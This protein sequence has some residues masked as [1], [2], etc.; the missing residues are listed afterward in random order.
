MQLTLKNASTA[1][2]GVSPSTRSTAAPR[3]SHVAHASKAQKG[4]WAGMDAGNDVSDDQ[5]DI[6]R[7]RGMV[8]ELFQGWGG[9][10]GTQNAIMASSDYISQA[11]RTFNNVEDGFYISPSFLDKLSIHIAKNFMNLP[12]IK[13]PLILGIWGGKGQGK[14]FQC[15]LA[16]KKLGITPIVMSAGELE[17]GN[18]GEPAKLLRQ[19]YREA[20]DMIKKGKMCCL[21]IN[22]LDA[23][24][25]RFGLSTQYTVNNQMVNATLMNIADNPTNVQLPGVYK[26]EEIPRV[27]IVCTGNDFSTLYAPLIRDGR[28]E[29]YYWNP[30]REDRV[31][32]CMGIFAEDNLNRGQVEQLVDA[33]PGQSIDFFG[34]LRAR[35]YDD[36]VREFVAQIGHENLNKRLINSKEGKVKFEKPTMSL[37]VLMHYGKSLVGEQDNVKR[38]QLADAYLAGAEL[39]GSTG[40]SVPEQ[41]KGAKNLNLSEN[42]PAQ[43][44]SWKTADS[45]KVAEAPRAAAPAP[46]RYAPAPTPAA[47]S[48]DRWARESAP[49]AAPAQRAAA[50]PAGALSASDLAKFKIAD[51]VEIGAK[52]GVSGGRNATRDSLTS[53]LLKAGVTAAD[54]T[55]GQMAELKS[56]GSSFASAPSTPSYSAPAPAAAAPAAASGDRWSS[57]SSSSR[58]SSSGGVSSGSADA[59]LSAGDLAAFKIADLVEIG[60]KKGVSGGRNA[61]RDGLV[62]ALVKAGVSLTDLS[63]GQLVDLGTKLGKAGLS[64]DINAARAEL[65]SLVGGSGSATASWRASPAP[66]STP[67]A[68]QQP[69]ASWRSTPSS[70]SSSSGGDRWASYSRGSTPAASGSGSASS[71]GG[72]LSA[73]DL[74]VLRIDD[75]RDLVSKTGAQLPREATKDGVI[76]AL[77]S[78]GVSLNDCTR[79]MLVDLATK[80]GA[81][82]AKDAEGLRRN[83]ASVVGGSSGGSA[84]SWRSSPAP[85]A[86]SAP[87]AAPA[88]GDR[89]SKYSAGSTKAASWRRSGSHNA[90]GSKLSASDLSILR[91]DDLA[92][93][94]KKTGAQV[95]RDST[96]DG[97]ISALVSKGVS[98]NEC[99][100]G[101]L[102]DLANKLGAPMARDVDGLRKNLA[103]AVGKGSYSAAPAASTSNWRSAPAESSSSSSSSGDRWASYSRSSGGSSGSSAGAS[104][105]SGAVY[106]ADLSA[107]KVDVLADMARKKGISVRNATKDSLVRELTRS[108]TLNDLSRGQLVEI[109]HNIGQSPSGSVEQMRSAVAAAASQ[110]QSARSTAGSR[111]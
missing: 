77:V 106:E 45:A 71:A 82:L 51:L 98:L 101:M 20:S 33:F 57:Y 31:G 41:Y 108:L 79:G 30:T 87:A 86:S 16:F 91:I 96:K 11:Q 107:F 110:R 9:T 100:R 70:S 47:S 50:A 21:F 28:M 90:S 34:A 5:Q 105:G 103:S 81:S 1:K 18:A 48:G 19:R 27:P 58:G 73:A 12:K 37:D 25:G 74:S 44:G 15:M 49:A 61:T 2:S 80:L 39:A 32:V 62:D 97:V 75:L 24:A 64:R 89:W 60:A 4:R 22:D 43:R 38:V 92:E 109:L 54:L 8:D 99:T 84:A 65:A 7:G 66:T 67:A 111:W 68:S 88:G 72:K 52:K 29:K 104:G 17:S 102:V 59:K 40:S 69:P 83:L 76:S 94:A 14:T 78:K 3:Q 36:K 63:R 35:V 56:G 46:E 10:A 53:A 6:A 85:A 55:K 95:P 42:M 23:G 93:L 26:N 13:V